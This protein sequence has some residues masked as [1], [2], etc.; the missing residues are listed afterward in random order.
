MGTHMSVQILNKKY[1]I[2]LKE[3]NLS[4]KKLE[5]VPDSIGNLIN[6]QHLYLQQNQLISL[7]DSIGNLI[8]LQRLHL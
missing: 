4:F 2:N 7:P 5:T 3:L 6:L 1:N 8:N